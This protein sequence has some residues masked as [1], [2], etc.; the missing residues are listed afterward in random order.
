MA[1]FWSGFLVFLRCGA[2]LALAPAFGEQT[3]PLRVRL[4]ISIAMTFA[5]APA[6]S[7]PA[8]PGA[9]EMLAETVNGLLLGAGF[10]LFVLALQTAGMIASQATSLA[11]L[12]TG[13]AAEPQSSFSAVLLLSGLALACMSGL[14]VKLAEALI[15]SHFVLPQGRFPNGADVAGWGVAGV[16]RSFSLAFALAAPFLIAGALYNIA[17]GAINRAMPTLMVVMVGA[18]AL[19]FGGLALL[20]LMAPMMLQLW[21]GALDRFLISPFD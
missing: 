5:V 12:F 18:P 8:A 2:A 6:V 10:R 9:A 3:I 14:H 20:A 4:G 11:Q 15:A 7:A 13:A 19:T 17:L 16:S 1:L 21:L